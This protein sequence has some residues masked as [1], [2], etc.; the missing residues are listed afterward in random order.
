MNMLKIFS[1]GD[2]IGNYC[3]G[4]FGRDDYEDKTCVMVT[5]KYAVFQYEDGQGTLLNYREG[6]EDY[7]KGEN[8]KPSFERTDED[9]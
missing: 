2:V 4:Y 8:W 3:N 5:P 1:V 6:L 7:A 9:Y